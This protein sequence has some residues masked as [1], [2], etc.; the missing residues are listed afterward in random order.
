M[1]FSIRRPVSDS[2]RHQRQG[3]VA[4]IELAILLPL[5]LLT[6]A[7]LILCARYMWHYTVAQKAAQD[8]AR[9]MSTVSIAEMKSKTMA[10]HAKNIAVEIAKRE[11]AELAPGEDIGSPDVFCGVN[12][13]GFLGGQAA[14][15]KTVTV[16]VAFPVT[17]T[18]FGTYLGPDGWLINVKATVP[19]VG[20]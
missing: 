17:D 13:C 10:V 12:T 16:F 6:L 18:F 9:Y 3:G 7:P 15:P 5:L 11:V 14:V 2:R 20:K 19:Y 8:A 1:T 4:A